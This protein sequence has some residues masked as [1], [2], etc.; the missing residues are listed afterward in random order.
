MSLTDLQPQAGESV[1]ASVSDEDS[2]SLD[3]VRWQWSKS[4]EEDGSGEDI[5]GATSRTYTPAT[6]DI[7]YYLRATA[8]YS[9][10][11]GTERDSASAVTEYAVEERPVANSQP[12][13]TDTDDDIDG[14]QQNRSVRETAEVLS[15][16]HISEPTRPY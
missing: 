10:G 3:Q 2:N 6:E 11:L 14:A 1:E 12:A 4:M 7:G 15:L 9:D 16:I 13:F 5:S 8:T